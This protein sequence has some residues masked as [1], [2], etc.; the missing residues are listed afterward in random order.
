MWPLLRKEKRFA[1][2]VARALQMI[3]RSPT[4]STWTRSE[5]AG[6]RYHLNRT[7][8]MFSFFSDSQDID[9]S[10]LKKIGK[11]EPLLVLERD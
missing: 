5:I 2:G 4:R 10:A 6:R 9:K 7:D 11:S 8:I 3:M 1:S